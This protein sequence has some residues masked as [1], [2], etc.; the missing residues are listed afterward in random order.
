MSEQ[1]GG[2]SD[3]MMDIP[4]SLS[5]ELGRTQMKVRDV[6]SLATGMVIELEKP[7]EDPVEL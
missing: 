1:A 3:F 7:V 6:M 2:K 5:V 4:V